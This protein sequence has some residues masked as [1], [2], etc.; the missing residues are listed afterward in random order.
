MGSDETP[1][2]MALRHV[3]EGEKHIADQIAL[4]ERLRLMGLPT[5][6]AEDLLERFHLLQASTRSICAGSQTSASSGSGTNKGISSQQRFY[7]ARK[8]IQ[9][10]DAS[11]A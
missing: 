7:E 2:E 3:L 5:E 9:K 11:H 8:V 4:I 10:N 6:D 1:A